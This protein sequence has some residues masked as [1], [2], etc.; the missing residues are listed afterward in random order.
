MTTIH[1]YY[2]AFIEAG[3]QNGAS[4]DLLSQIKET[5]YHM[6]DNVIW[7][8]PEQIIGYQIEIKSKL[9]KLVIEYPRNGEPAWYLE[10]KRVFQTFDIFTP[11]SKLEDSPIHVQ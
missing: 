7:K 6:M 4:P 9:A 8:A 1:D 10:M 3:L 5:Y 2:Q 11:P